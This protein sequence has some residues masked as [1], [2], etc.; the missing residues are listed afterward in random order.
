M[1]ENEILEN[2]N[3]IITVP[4]YLEEM[5]TSEENET[6]QENETSEVVDYSSILEEMNTRLSNIEAN[7]VNYTEALQGILTNMY[8]LDFVGFT[9]LF[10][11]CL[12]WL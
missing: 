1:N 10:S 2:E 12:C 5:K 9:F 6:S 7:T 8:F 11:F 4:D 3:I